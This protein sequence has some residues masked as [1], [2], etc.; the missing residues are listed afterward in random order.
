LE[1]GNL[2]RCWGAAELLVSDGNLMSL[3]DML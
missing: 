2:L 3:R 1:L